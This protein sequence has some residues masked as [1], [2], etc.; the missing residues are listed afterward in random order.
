MKRYGNLYDR[1]LEVDVHMPDGR[2]INVGTVHWHY[3]QYATYVRLDER[4]VITYGYADDLYDA[5][6][7]QDQA[8]MDLCKGRSIQCM[9]EQNKIY[10]PYLR[11]YWEV[12]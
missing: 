4:D 11:N 10:E 8:V 1:L 6:D 7:M 5:R 2:A 12:V 3:G 9:H